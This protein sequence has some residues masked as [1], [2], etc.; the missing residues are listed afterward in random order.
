MCTKFWPTGHLWASGLNKPLLSHKISISQSMTTEKGPHDMFLVLEPI[1]TFQQKEK[2]WRLHCR[3]ASPLTIAF[4]Y[5]YYFSFATGQINSHMYCKYGWEGYWKF[6]FFFVGK[7]RA[8]VTPGIMERDTFPCSFNFSKTL[9]FFWKRTLLTNGLFS[10]FWDC[11]VKDIWRLASKWCLR[12]WR[13]KLKIVMLNCPIPGCVSLKMP[14]CIHIHLY[15]NKW[16]STWWQQRGTEN[17][18]PL[19]VT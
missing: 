2:E 19:A 11:R 13:W 1:K 15:A 10:S 4:H 6:V 17:A 3:V 18:W 12:D 7:R 16:L 14:N 9:E 5:Y 8:S